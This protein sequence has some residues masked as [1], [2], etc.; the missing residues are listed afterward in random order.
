M[1]KAKFAGSAS[2][3][4]AVTLA[5]GPASAQ[6]QEK[7]VNVYNWSDYIDESIL[8]DFQNET[9]IRVVYDVFDSNEVLET[10]LLA[11]GTDYEKRQQEDEG[12][13]APALP[14]LHA[15]ISAAPRPCATAVRVT[16][17]MSWP[18]VTISN[19]TTT[20]NAP[21]S[22]GMHSRSTR[23]Q[24]APADHTDHADADHATGQAATEGSSQSEPVV[25]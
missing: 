20:R 17:V 7:V 1:I 22:I 11:G 14:Q 10:K 21:R 3:L 25:R 23:F 15:V 9:G 16:S 2:A 12:H 13:S 18:G 19:P 8:E 4:L 5:F 6:E 24:R